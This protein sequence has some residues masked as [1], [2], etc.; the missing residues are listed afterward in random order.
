MAECIFCRIIA[1]EIP[2]TAVYEDA[3][4]FAFRDINP[5]APTHILVIPRRHI[6]TLNDTGEEDR[7]LLGRLLEA[8]RV[9]AR[10][11]GLVAGGYRVVMNVGEGAG[12]SVFHAHLHVLGGRPL[13]WPPG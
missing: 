10:D 7:A 3:E 2:A 12:Q 13:A 11:Q 5:A 8:A 1:G 9:I 6:G 4:I